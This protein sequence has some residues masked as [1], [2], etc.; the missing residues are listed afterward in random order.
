MLPLAA[1]WLAAPSSQVLL[2][3]SSPDIVALTRGRAVARSTSDSGATLPLVYIIGGQSQATGKGLT[4]ELTNGERDRAAALD[5]RVSVHYPP[6][7]KILCAEAGKQLCAELEEALTVSPPLQQNDPRIGREVNRV[8]G[9]AWTHLGGDDPRIASGSRTLGEVA[10]GSQGCML[11]PEVGFGLRMAEAKPL[12]NINII[13]VTAP[14]SSISIYRNVMYPTL[15]SELQ[16]FGEVHGEFELGGMLWLQGE[17]E[18]G[19]N[20]PDQVTTNVTYPAAGDYGNQL[21]SLITDLR[22]D[23]GLQVPFATALLHFRKASWSSEDRQPHNV[24]VVNR[25]M[26][27]AANA[28]KSV[29][30]VDGHQ[31]INGSSTVDLPRYF[32]EPQHCV[33]P[34]IQTCL[35]PLWPLMQRTCQDGNLQGDCSPGTIACLDTDLHFTARG[36]IGVGGAFAEAF[37][38]HER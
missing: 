19:A 20:E 34:D 28:L 32:E 15:L 18:A 21:Q 24:E 2:P 16:A 23:T 9:D 11:G 8:S 30:V 29:Y 12:R 14:G 10:G 1:G 17:S 36:Q 6:A 3:A 26:Q 22:A 37:L 27:K 31:F 5:N 13:K 33:P 35:G 25:G 4:K 38:A 7:V